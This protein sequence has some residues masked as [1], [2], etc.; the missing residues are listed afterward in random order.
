MRED[1]GMVQKYKILAGVD[2]VKKDT[3]RYIVQENTERVTRATSDQ[4]R[5]AVNSVKTE[6]RGHFF[7]QRVVEG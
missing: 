6:L 2:K 3:Y 7:S 1:T 5:L 4:S